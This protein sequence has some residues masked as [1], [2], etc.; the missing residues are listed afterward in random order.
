MTTTWGSPRL[1]PATNQ[2]GGNIARTCSEH[3]NV[4]RLG[5]AS[6][7]QPTNTKTQCDKENSGKDP[8]CTEDLYNFVD[9]RRGD[10]HYQQDKSRGLRFSLNDNAPL[11]LRAIYTDKLGGH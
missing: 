10:E 7:E 4:S 8:S 1:S 9:V 11:L 6:A 5:I 3:H 2:R